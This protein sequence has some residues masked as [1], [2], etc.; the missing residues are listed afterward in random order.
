MPDVSPFFDTGS[1]LPRLGLAALHHLERHLRQWG[2]N[3]R[4]CGRSGDRPSSPRRSALHVPTA[5]A[6]TPATAPSTVE[7]SEPPPPLCAGFGH[8]SVRWSRR[9][10]RGRSLC[11]SWRRYDSADFGRSKSKLLLDRTYTKRW[12]LHARRKKRAKPGPL[13]YFRKYDTI[14]R[15]SPS[16]ERPAIDGD[17]GAHRI[18]YPDSLA[19]L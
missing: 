6:L 10:H 7:G 3:H 13:H 5:D 2:P 14:F 11:C 17:R 4:R 12:G 1:I 16:V 15:D 19:A 9:A 8:V 18:R